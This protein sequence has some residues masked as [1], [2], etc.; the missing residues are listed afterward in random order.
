MK[1]LYFF[2]ISLITLS[3]RSEIGFTQIK[4]LYD[5]IPEKK[6]QCSPVHGFN[7]WKTGII[8]NF[9]SFGDQNS[10]TIKLIRDL[11]YLQ[12]DGVT[13]D[14]TNL[15]RKPAKYL[16]A[17]AI[18][19]IIALIDRYTQP[20][21][22][23]DQESL[24]IEL[25]ETLKKTLKFDQL[26]VHAAEQMASAR[27]EIAQL[28]GLGQE[29]V[30][31]QKKIITSERLIKQLDAMH[32]TD[33]EKAATTQKRITQT[34]TE[35][36]TI[37]QQLEG[38]KQRLDQKKN[39]DRI[40]H[41]NDLNEQSLRLLVGYIV[42]SLQETL[43]VKYVPYAT[44]QILLAFLWKKTNDKAEFL[45]YFATAIPGMNI[46]NRSEWLQ[47]EYTKEI[48][49]HFKTNLDNKPELAASN[50]QLNS[51]VGFSHYIWNSSGL[52]LLISSIS[53][54][55]YQIGD[56]KY[57]F[58]DC[59]E[60]SLRNFLNIRIYNATTGTLDYEIIEALGK[61]NGFTPKPT[62]GVYYKKHN[63]ITKIQTKPYYDAWTQVVSGLPGVEYLNAPGYEI[64]P[65][66]GLSNILAVI[67]N[68]FFNNS[69]EFN[70]MTNSK[71]LDY[72]VKKF[73]D[74]KF[75]LTWKA[76][77]LL[78]Q[79]T[80]Q[81]VD[82]EDLA[83]DILPSEQV[84]VDRTNIGIRVIFSINNTI[85]FSWKFTDNHF[86][87]SAPHAVLPQRTGTVGA[88]TKTIYLDTTQALNN[89]NLLCW[90]IDLQSLSL[91]QKVLS[92][93]ITKQNDEMVWDEETDAWVGQETEE[94]VPTSHA[95][96]NNYLVLLAMSL[97]LRN[98]E[99][100]I[101]LLNLVL[102]RTPDLANAHQ[103]LIRNLIHT[104]PIKD[105]HY[106]DQVGWA[107]VE[108]HME[109]LYPL[110]N[111][112]PIGSNTVRAI[113]H[114]KNES[115]YPLAQKVVDHAYEHWTDIRDKD[116]YITMINFPE[117]MNLPRAKEIIEKFKKIEALK[118]I[119]DAIFN[120]MIRKPHADKYKD[121]IRNLTQITNEPLS[122]QA[123]AQLGNILELILHP[124]GNEHEDDVAGI[125]QIIKLILNKTKYKPNVSHVAKHTLEDE[126]DELYEPLHEAIV[127]NPD[128]YDVVLEIL[129]NKRREL[130]KTVKAVVAQTEDKILLDKIMQSIQNNSIEDLYPLANEIAQQIKKEEQVSLTLPQLF[131]SIVEFAY[132][133]FSQVVTKLTFKNEF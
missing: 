73:S 49:S 89:V 106:A 59:G 76:K 53:D 28:G 98:H 127:A 8:E 122:P 19:K 9:W 78:P 84:D 24:K 114:A 113:I 69:D 56:K 48:F 74:Q 36:A 130:Y 90:Y 86:V 66:N 108:N 27:K 25:F 92:S 30:A 119:E 20:L 91:I 43:Q 4:G 105:A 103:T 17:A 128:F 116:S 70:Q 64:S 15:A 45:D 6:K 112:I 118:E 67:N 31:L 33:K 79:S 121:I 83:A 117:I 82:T 21:S 52:P 95:V 14:V 35:I 58:P 34:K 102:M 16:N 133:L 71:K 12:P 77:K 29:R 120:A 5:P 93:P 81:L 32:Y 109:F 72:L 104:L 57:H 110:L 2:I 44:H 99:I 61:L 115:L 50:Y 26:V 42:G 13:F 80:T 132:G 18:G 55:T 10:D 39:L 7:W 51:F 111:E 22:A 60:T 123:D 40:I 38:I 131:N 100:V 1:S 88:L 37:Q 3:V 62:A 23:G 65:R 54:A 124:D 107:I 129:S 41:N 101:P 126:L 63:N 85:H 75:K 94:Y 11:F 46:A 97:N 87:L 68:L 125:L 47:E 96:V